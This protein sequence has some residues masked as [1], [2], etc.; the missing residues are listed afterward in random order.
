MKEFKLDEILSHLTGTDDLDMAKSIIDF[1]VYPVKEDKTLDAPEYYLIASEAVVT[2]ISFVGMFA[3]LEIDF[4]NAGIEELHHVMN[5]INRFHTGIN[6][7]N[8][9]MLSTIT[10]LDKDASHIMSL[11]NPLLCVRGYSE[12]NGSTILQIVYSVENI[13]FS[14]YQID[15]NK[16]DADLDREAYE[17]E[18]LEVTNEA[19]AAAQDI[20]GE[21]EKDEIMKS[22]FKPEFGLRTPDDKRKNNNDGVRVSGEKAVQVKADKQGKDSVISRHEDA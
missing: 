14:E 8:L 15:F 11:A 22:M 18:A 1:A 9:L 17:L 2:Q 21:D 10:S 16:I 4:R 5:V 19:I 7:R 12:G 3:M 13:G 6:S 20:L